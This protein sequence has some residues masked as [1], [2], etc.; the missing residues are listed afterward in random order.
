VTRFRDGAAAALR[1]PGPYVPGWFPLV[2]DR[3]HPLVGPREPL[4]ARVHGLRMLLDPADYTQRKIWYRSFE[5]QEARL[6]ARVLR[7]GDSVVDVGA[8][9]GYFT[10]LAAACVGPSGRVHAFEPV[11]ANADVLERNV[12]LNDLANVR[13][14]RAAVDA[15]DGELTLGLRPEWDDAGGVS[16]WYTRGG[17]TRQVTAPARSLDSYLDDERV[18]LVKVDAE[19]MEARVVA[20]LARTLRERPPDVLLLE[21]NRGALAAQGATPE[22]VTGPLRA[23]GYELQRLD[24]LGRRRLRRVG[25]GLATLVAHRGALLLSKD[26]AL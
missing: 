16:G 6:V 21:L 8:N 26:S 9:A 22:D 4:E 11:P 5:P 14:N 20:G 15:A 17:A 23:A 3:L 2:A 18:R 1:L 24:A 19:G 13:V 10:L 12:A 25:P 7:P